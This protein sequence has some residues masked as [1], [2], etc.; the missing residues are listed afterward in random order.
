MATDPGIPRAEG[1]VIM[2]NAILPPPPK[3]AKKHEPS[4]PPPPKVP[5]GVKMVQGAFLDRWFR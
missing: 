1:M 4:I 3:R 5:A 2:R